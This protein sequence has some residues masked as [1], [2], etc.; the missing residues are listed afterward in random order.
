MPKR[1]I[2][3]LRR[4]VSAVA[5]RRAYLAPREKM[6]LDAPITIDLDDS[7][8]TAP[9]TATLKPPLARRGAA[10]KAQLMQRPPLPRKGKAAKKKVTLVDA[11]TVVK[12]KWDPPPSTWDSSEHAQGGIMK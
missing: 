1:T 2:L 6:Q 10:K 7:L 3:P 9:V 4:A 11:T 8:K 12:Q 5:R